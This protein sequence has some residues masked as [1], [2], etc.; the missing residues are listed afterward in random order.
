MIMHP[1]AG[2]I[3]GGGGGKGGLSP[4]PLETWLPPL[5]NI[6]W[7]HNIIITREKERER[8]VAA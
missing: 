1:I 6:P 2:F 5:E 7:Y 8:D 4:P 3:S